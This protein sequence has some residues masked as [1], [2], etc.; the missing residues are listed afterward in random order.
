VRTNRRFTLIELLVVIAIIAILAA[1][2]LP[3]LS[4]A[5]EK[6]RQAS[7]TSNAKQLMLGCLMYA[8][9]YK[10]YLPNFYSS[11]NHPAQWPLKQWS[12]DIYPYV[13]DR[14]VY[15][16]PSRTVANENG[17]DASFPV[18][19]LPAAYE[20]NDYVCLGG[21]PGGDSRLA[22]VTNP[23][24]TICIYEAIRGQN[25]CGHYWQTVGGGLH[26]YARPS[27]WSLQTNSEAS[28][29]GNSAV[30][31]WV[32]GHVASMTSKTWEGISAAQYGQYWQR[33]R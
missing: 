15:N 27:G 2:L 9:D 29:H 14:N 13:N 18:V 5:R 7:C 10:E 17:G 19:S 21:R 11:L 31:G 26:C 24:S 28:P 23:S 6:A 30:I 32:D 16:C 4:K 1:M 3:A 22:P 25:Y 33:T 12:H 8:D 20:V